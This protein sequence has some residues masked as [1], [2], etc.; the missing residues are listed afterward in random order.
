MRI[1]LICVKI[2]FLFQYRR[3][4]N[5]P[6]NVFISAMTEVL[7]VISNNLSLDI[8]KIIKIIGIIFL[9]YYSFYWDI[10]TEACIG[11]AQLLYMN[12]NNFRLRPEKKKAGK[13]FITRT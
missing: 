2:C 6:C 10:S 11:N 5:I 4:C 8:L 3:W 12:T 9:K 7:K 1:I 13:K